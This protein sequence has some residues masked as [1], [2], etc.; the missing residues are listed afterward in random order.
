MKAEIAVL[1]Q[2]RSQIAHCMASYGDE[3]EELMYK[4]ESLVIE[5]FQKG[6]NTKDGTNLFCP[7]CNQ[8]STVYHLDWESI[9]C[10]FCKHDVDLVEW[11]IK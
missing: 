3:P 8:V 6:L 7:H 2:I 10:W 5:W 4:L 9:T 1:K 11:V